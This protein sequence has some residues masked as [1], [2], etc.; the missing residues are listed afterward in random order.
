VEGFDFVDHSDRQKIIG[1]ATALGD[2]CMEFKNHVIIPACG[3]T[4]FFAEAEN[5]EYIS[6]IKDNGYGNSWMKE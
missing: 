6:E 5:V 4:F 2:N 1:L 3:R